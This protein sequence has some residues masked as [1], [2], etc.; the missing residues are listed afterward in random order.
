[1]LCFYQAPLYCPF[2]TQQPTESLKTK[3]SIRSLLCKKTCNGLPFQAE[4]EP[5]SSNWPARPSDVNPFASETPSSPTTV[6]VLTPLQSHW[7]T[8][9]PSK[10]V[11]GHAPAWASN[12]FLCLSSPASVWLVLSPPSHLCPV[13]IFSMKL[14]QVAQPL[15]TCTPHAALYFASFQSTHPL[16]TNNTE[17]TVLMSS[18]SPCP[19]LALLPLC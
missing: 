15:P 3:P 10:T 14:L 5:K 13:L 18:A 16:L 8:R 17:L 2:S 4:R 12:C 6:T 11:T 9:S 1:M 19:P 7:L